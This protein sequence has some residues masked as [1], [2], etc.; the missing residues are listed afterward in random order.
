MFFYPTLKP[1]RVLTASTVCEGEWRTFV[2]DVENGLHK[3]IEVNH[4]PDHQPTILAAALMHDRSEKA[5]EISDLKLENEILRG[6]LAVY[7]QEHKTTPRFAL[8]W[9]TLFAL[10]FLG[11]SLFWH[12]AHGLTT[13]STTE[14]VNPMEMLKLNIWLDNF[15]SEA[16]RIIHTHRTTV[17]DAVRTSPSWLIAS[18]LIPH[19][20]TIVTIVLGIMSV[21]R[22]ERRVLSICF[23]AAATMSG[24]D[25]LFLSSASSQTAVSAICQIAC[26]LVSH[27]DP[28][29]AI[30]LSSLIMFGTFLASMC[31]TSTE[32]I[33]HS[34]AA[35]INTAVLVVSIVLRT[36]QLPAMPIALALAAVR[37]YTII[38]T[39]TGATIEVR[40]DDGKVV[41][42]DPVKPGILFRFKQGL[43][44]RFAQLR[45]SMPPLVRVNPTA[46]VRVETP[47]GI[48]TGFFCAN[49]IVT[50]GHVL[51]P[52]K[53]ASICIGVAKYQTTL[54]RHIE[55][56]DIALLKIPQQVQNYPRL[57]IASKIETEWVCIY[58]P[59][60]EGAIVQSVVPGHQVDDCID[61]AVPTRDGMSG[62]PLVNPDGRVMAVHLTNTG[63]TG[64]AQILTQADV[65]D[66]PKSSTNEDKLKQEIEE[67]KKQLAKCNQSSTQADIVG[68]VRAAMAREMTILREELNKELR[69]APQ[70]DQA[71]GKT[72]MKAR[73]LRMAGSKPRRQRGPVFTEEE[74]NRLLESGLTPDEIRDMVDRLYDKEVAGFPEWDPMD[75][76][77]DPNE[78]W[79][80]ES[81]SNFGQ[82]QVKVPSFNQYME[83][84]YDVKDVEN[85]LQSL[86]CA[87]VDAIGPLYPITAHC[88]G[89]PLCPAMLCLVDRYAASRGLS[90]PSFGLPYTQRRVPKNREEGPEPAAPEIHKLDAW[91]ALRL[92]PSRRVVPDDYPV[93]CNL[94]INR[95]IYEEKLVDDPLLG[96]L[97][98][99]DP[100]LSFAPAV[101]GPQAYT[102]S[103]EK[104]TY[105]EPS[106]FWELYPK[107]CAFADKQWRKHYNFLEDTRVMHITATEKN[108]DST[109]GYPKCELHESER[110]YLECNGWAPYIRE[111][112]RV[113]SGARPRVLWYCFLKKEQ[114]KKEKIKDGDIRQI[115]CPD[116]I[117][118]R[119]G[120]ALEQHQ[121]NLMK[122][123]TD[124]SSGQCGWTPFFGGFAEKMR[125]LDKNKIIEFDWTRFD[126]TIPRALLKHIKDLRWEKINKQHRERYRHVHEWYV[127]NLL[128]RYVLMPTGEVTIQRRGNPSGQISTTMDNNMVNYWLQAFE[129][130]YL[131]QGKDIETLW[132]EYDTIVYGDDRL[133]SSP[134][135][136]EDYV[137]RVVTMYKEVFGM[138]VKPEK[139]KV[140][141]SIVGASFC[142]FTVGK[143]YQP[144]PSNPEKLWASLVTPCQKLPDEF[145][146]YGKLLSFKI[147]MHNSE[148][149]PFKDYIEKCIAA[150]E[151]GRSLPKITDEQLDR[152]WRGGP[153]T[154][155][156]G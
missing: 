123:N 85:M 148:D 145:A 68:L 1:D 156:N 153:K 125:R 139:V 14:S 118:S 147:L 30:C 105:A 10:V 18:T 141:D 72:K 44:K 36:M 119:I 5:R 75:D 45:S 140:T 23:L 149:H 81:D 113:D 138:W 93:V 92:P 76:G 114:L 40:S 66:P 51:G 90:P 150:L 6:Q 86:T 121:N 41:S 101:W 99:C 129:F 132:S 109:P 15:V 130:A 111:F 88:I 56:K 106:R 50:A 42:K 120:A 87:D 73:R 63:F 83:R 142:G 32:F 46:V 94:P 77:Y 152:L 4:I 21:Y 60:G 89:S 43:R 151:H 82:R 26:V 7:R 126:G 2:L 107:E 39:P 103:F 33:Q 8:S 34:R 27:I 134:S 131:N 98:P 155:P 17:M 28:L 154:N 54:V 52:H 91:E 35:S 37:A 117:Y 108:I 70:Y 25:W 62:A 53:V 12:S 79:T 48:G 74:Y 102:K 127:Q 3:A 22:S 97:P 115:I 95:P 20:W 136:P 146:L 112:K 69:S 31:C 67:L 110:D 78:D 96:L 58:S 16:K 64:G 11:F 84:E 104:F 65:T 128:T 100:D 59:D 9:T 116:V 29:G 61:Y 124:T 135:V 49:Y 137:Q 38:T 57:K 144:I 47:D 122:K 71:K 55:G 133:T 13:T 24:G 80:F 19:L 143:N